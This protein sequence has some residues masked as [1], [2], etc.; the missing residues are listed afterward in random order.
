[1]VEV[2]CGV[3]ATVA[4]RPSASKARLAHEGRK[5]NFEFHY[6]ICDKEKSR[7]EHFNDWESVYSNKK[8]ELLINPNSGL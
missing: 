1:M 4:S 7:P 3:H 8:Y 6:S 5:S 2:S